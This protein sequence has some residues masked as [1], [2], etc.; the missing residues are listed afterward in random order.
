AIY[1]LDLETRKPAKLPESD[2]L[3]SPRWS[4]DG[5]YI[6]AITLDSLQLKLF[7]FTTQK[8][9]DLA[10][11]FV[12]YPTW[13]GDGRYVYFDGILD[14]QESYF[15]VQIADGKLER[16]FRLKGFQAAGGAFGNWSGLAPDGSPL[17]VRD[18]SIQEIYALDWDTP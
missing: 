5:R 2:G 12:A 6:A 14:N 13:S 11:L 10:E 9:S 3:F 15:R 16:L 17:L 8:W 4:P 18:A 1:M 7:D